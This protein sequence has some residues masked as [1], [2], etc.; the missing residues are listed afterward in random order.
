MIQT[1]KGVSRNSHGVM[2]FAL[3]QLPVSCLEIGHVVIRED[4][5]DVTSRLGFLTPMTSKPLLWLS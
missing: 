1:L 2:E 5:F 4:V 3:R